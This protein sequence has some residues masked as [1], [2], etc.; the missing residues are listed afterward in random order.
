MANITAEAVIPLVNSEA[1][2]LQGDKWQETQ[3]N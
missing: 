3:V 1:Q 2:S